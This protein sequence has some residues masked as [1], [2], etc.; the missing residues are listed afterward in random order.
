MPEILSTSP[1]R[2]LEA[3]QAAM[4][5]RKS[6]EAILREARLAYQAAREDSRT[7]M[8]GAAAAA[9]YYTV[10]VPVESTNRRPN[11]GPSRPP[12]TSSCRLCRPCP[13]PCC[14][15]PCRPSLC[16]C[17]PSLCLSRRAFLHPWMCNLGPSDP[18]HHSSCIWAPQDSE[19]L[20]VEM[21]ILAAC[22]L[23]PGNHNI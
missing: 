6:S 9:Y 21:R 19:P 5:R 8:A 20:P 16:L 17:R 3:L 7:Y 18:F 4:S 12:T 2:L 14:R 23:C 13:C 10:L 22:G 11:S 1:M 15:S